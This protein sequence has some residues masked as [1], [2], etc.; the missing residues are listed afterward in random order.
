MRASF[1]LDTGTD[2]DGGNDN[3]EQV[4]VFICHYPYH[5][6]PRGTEMETLESNW[7]GTFLA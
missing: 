1:D 2:D 7:T 3:D 4:F 6:D 5:T